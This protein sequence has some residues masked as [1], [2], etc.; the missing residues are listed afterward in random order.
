[1]LVRGLG[2]V[3]R[4]CGVR[5]GCRYVGCRGVRGVGL[6]VLPLV[7]LVRPPLRVLLPPFSLSLFWGVLALIS[8]SLM[9]MKIT[10]VRDA[11]RV[12]RYVTDGGLIEECRQCCHEDENDDNRRY[13]HARVRVYACHEDGTTHALHPPHRDDG[14]L[15]IEL[16]R[17][18]AK[19]LPYYYPGLFG[20]LR[21]EGSFKRFPGADGWHG[22]RVLSS[23]PL[24][25]I[26]LCRLF[27]GLHVVD[28]SGI[29]PRLQFYDQTGDA[30]QH[31]SYAT[32]FHSDDV[33]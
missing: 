1:M 32:E 2:F 15:Q 12:C 26:A 13:D 21:A 30:S 4:A 9:H 6:F 29:R 5:C 22:V 20:F 25:L 27:T 31:T 10:H 8:S 14:I 16:D 7:F 28:K 17:K 3:V 11:T 23:P 18:F 19:G 33:L 24:T